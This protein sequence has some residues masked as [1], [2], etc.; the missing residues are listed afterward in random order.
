MK[1][2]L[3][4]VVLGLL[5]TSCSNQKETA[6]ENCADESVINLASS[7]IALPYPGL[8]YSFLGG[9]HRKADNLIKEANSVDE[10]VY[11]QVKKISEFRWKNFKKTYRKSVGGTVF[12]IIRAGNAP[13]AKR[14]LIILPDDLVSLPIDDPK[15]IEYKD[16]I[17][18]E[19]QS[20]GNVL[21]KIRKQEETLRQES[22]KIYLKERRKIVKKIDVKRKSQVPTYLS[23]LEKCEMSYNKTPDSF[24]IKWK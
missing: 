14:S 15:V 8:F 20:M 19:D 6:L 5:I 16:K 12:G 11:E 22:S 1:K 2:L 24:L 7:D 3:G 10:K 18:K 23:F 17:M 4:I 21:D 13:P 9:K